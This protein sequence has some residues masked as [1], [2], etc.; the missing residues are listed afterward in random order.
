[1]IKIEENNIK[2]IA[3]MSCNDKYRYRLTRIWDENKAIAGIIM[4]NPSKASA[5]KTDNTIMNMSN[6]L[7]DNEYGGIDVVNLFSYMTTQKKY[8]KE[9]NNDYE[10]YN[11]EHI[12]KLV[13]ERP[14]TI[15]AWGSNKEEH[16]HRKKEVEKL[17]VLSQQ[18]LKCFMNENER[19]ACH[20][21]L[22]NSR[23]K[24][25]EYPFFYVKI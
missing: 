6:Y 1:M 5:I 2:S 9:R 12:V 16:K 8:L 10:K 19:M 21:L 23:W 13:D 18:K 20:P 7:I 22:L 14:L 15:I 24:L 3:V 4:L 11:D 25:V 17:L